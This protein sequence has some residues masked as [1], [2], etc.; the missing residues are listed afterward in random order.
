MLFKITFAQDTLSN[1]SLNSR[2]KQWKKNESSNLNIGRISWGIKGGYT[3]S[4]LWG[5]EIDYI[6]QNPQTKWQHGFHAGI[7][8]NSMLK[9]FFW[10]KHEIA[11]TTKGAQ[12]NRWDSLNNQVYESN[13]KTYY[14]DVYPIS[15][16]FH[17]Y[18]FQ[19]S[20][21]PYISALLAATIQKRDSIGNLYTDHSIYGSA[22]NFEEKEKYL[23]KFDFGVHG[24]VEYLFKFGL[25][26]HVRYNLGLIDIFQFA[27]S[28]TLQD[29]KNT[30]IKIYHQY[31]QFS[32]GYN[33]ARNKVLSEKKRN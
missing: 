10:L 1:Y 28:Y 21:G 13:F 17:A 4:N 3:L 31:F 20:A 6:F 29:S 11:F 30:P 16:T 19:I 25:F 8:V 14:L 33:F 26:F 9:K 23:Q 2:N 32:I 12:V 27:N 24:S 18:G 15:P 5:D 7:H 22:N